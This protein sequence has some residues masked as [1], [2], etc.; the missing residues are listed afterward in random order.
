MNHL[1]ENISHRTQCIVIM[2]D[3]LVHSKIN[4]H[5]DRLETFFQAPVKHCLKLFPK[6][7]QLEN[8]HSPSQVHGRSWPNDTYSQVV[9]KCNSFCRVV[10]FLSLFAQIWNLLQL[11]YDLTHG[12][13]PFIWAEC[14]QNHFDEVKARLIKPQ[15]LCLLIAWGHCILYSDTSYSHVRSF[16]W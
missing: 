4:H 16:L 9:K 1:L 12:N 15:L 14:H 13:H 11:I 8:D 7:C 2:D 10:S 6:K 3:L 5:M